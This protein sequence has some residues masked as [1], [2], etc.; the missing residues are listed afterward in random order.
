MS[1]S[2][3]ANEKWT[4]WRKQ[5]WPCSVPLG[6]GRTKRV[7]QWTTGEVEGHPLMFHVRCPPSP[8]TRVHF[9]FSLSNG[10]PK[11]LHQGLSRTTF[12]PSLAAVSGIFEKEIYEWTLAPRRMYTETRYPMRTRSIPTVTTRINNWA[13]RQSVRKK[14]LPTEYRR[15]QSGYLQKDPRRRHRRNIRRL[16]TTTSWICR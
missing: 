2:L 1:D 6:D 15:S 9:F 7:T 13:C 5:T 11:K 8:N 10:F 4:Q 12:S 3:L 14:N 16:S